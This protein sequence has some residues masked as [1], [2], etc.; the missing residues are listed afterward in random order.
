MKKIISLNE[1]D[2]K[3]II[4][5][6]IERIELYENIAGLERFAKNVFTGKYEDRFTDP[7]V[8]LTR[9]DSSS[10]SGYNSSNPDSE[11]EINRFLTKNN[12]T[13][14]T[15]KF[16]NNEIIQLKFKVGNEDKHFN[17]KPKIK[18][19]KK[20]GNWKFDGNKITYLT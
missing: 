15:W 10:A 6:V 20:D 7:D 18:L 8:G 5:K 14:G 12:I 4:N 13:S 9:N 11:K 19:S 2:L 17:L 3:K 1:S 16:I